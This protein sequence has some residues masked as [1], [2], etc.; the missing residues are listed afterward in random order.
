MRLYPARFSPDGERS[1]SLMVP[2][3]G[4]E[5][6]M[7]STQ[8][9]FETLAV[10]S[11]QQVYDRSNSRIDNTPFFVADQAVQSNAQSCAALMAKCYEEGLAPGEDK[12]EA[13]CLVSAKTF[14]GKIIRRVDTDSSE[15]A[16]GCSFT[17]WKD[18]TTAGQTCILRHRYVRLF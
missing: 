14:Y 16:C 12:D 7:A 5:H 4:M 11:T 3:P 2:L 9:T 1:P 6:N 18:S 8:G 10:L 17:T 15:C 13:R